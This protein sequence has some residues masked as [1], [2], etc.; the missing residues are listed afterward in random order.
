MSP[1]LRI[2]LAG[3]GLLLCLCAVGALIFVLWP[4]EP[5]REQFPV[6][7]TLFAPPAAAALGWLMR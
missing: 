6:A 4:L 2:L 3:L 1:R 7:P 5:V